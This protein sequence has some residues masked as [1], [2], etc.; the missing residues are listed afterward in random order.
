[1][2]QYNISVKN[3]VEFILRSGDICNYDQ[4]QL[5]N[6][7]AV[8]GTRIHRKIEKKL[9]REGN[10]SEVFLKYEEEFSD[11]KLTIDG[12]A[13][14]IK[15]NPLKPDIVEIK[16]TDI[17]LGRFD[18]EYYNLHWAQA[19]CYA[20]IFSKEN[21][22]SVCN[23]KLIYCNIGT[24]QIKEFVREFK[25]GELEEF[26]KYLLS[27][28]LQFIEITHNW[29]ETRNKSLKN[30]KF[31]FEDYREGQR[32]LAVSV[33]KAIK[34]KT[35]LFA[36][37][38]TGIGKTMSTVFPALKAMGEDRYE[39][40]FYLTAKTTT[41]M[42][43]K[44]SI[45]FLKQKS[46]LCL[47]A[48]TLYAKEKICMCDNVRTACNPDNC[49]Y[50]KGHYDR[51]NSAL[52]DALISDKTF[53][54]D[55]INEYSRKYTICPFEF[56]L[57]LCL[58]FDMIICDYNYVFD[59]SAHLRRFF[60]EGNTGKYVFLIDEAHNLIDRAREMF[61]VELKQNDFLELISCMREMFPEYSR[62]LG[63]INN[64]FNKKR[65]GEIVEILGKQYVFDREN[66]SE[67]I[68]LIT[69]ILTM[70]GNI[71]EINP[72]PEYFDEFLHLYF[73]MAFYIKMSDFYSENFCTYY[74][75]EEDVVFFKLLC[76]DPSDMLRKSFE[77]CISAI[78]F[79]A[80]M[81]PMKYFFK[82]IGGTETDSCLTLASP[83]LEENRCIISAKD[84]SS[85]YKKRNLYYEMTADYIYKT[86]NAKKGNYIVYFPS[87]RYMHIVYDI[88]KVK[89]D[90]IQTI[91]QEK[92]A[93][94]TE[95]EAFIDSFKDDETQQLIGFCVLGGVFSEGIDLKGNRL[96]GTVLVG[97]G[98][99][100][101]NIDKELMKEY[102][103][104][105]ARENY[106]IPQGF[107]YAYVFPGFTKILQSAGR[108]IRSEEDRGVIVLL[109]ERYYSQK[110]I[111]L[112][113]DEWKNVK[114]VELNDIDNLLR[115]FWES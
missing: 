7:R 95:K 56:S 92:S 39:K 66:D 60:D 32:E 73:D 53:D 25:F 90:G 28:Y 47:K 91:L 44:Q 94:D 86:F 67:L 77:K 99:P 37:A 69:D 45:D 81:I 46:G 102:F 50:A 83:F 70:S 62:A 30:L 15:L 76:L 19:K 64:H 14:S 107:D 112:F 11:F 42:L 84:I 82:L 78:L 34:T 101:I 85:S 48:I 55:M 110:Y 57:D 27:K 61:S 63:E 31:P 5:N 58:F 54:F 49:K 2:K 98:L 80:T 21:N 17:D 115:D 96:I 88:F 72:K 51:I 10:I 4:R 71:F 24:Y 74:S 106:E 68:D 8:L 23:V 89:Y 100:Q 108:V 87:Y 36:E 26:F 52:L 20:Y 43:P 59:P 103:D 109:D 40:L 75:V 114:F 6:E 104:Y 13:D 9:E 3:L 93:T 33:Y 18:G 79:S 105:K 65:S 38:P 1:M 29:M 113:P 111:D 22:Y 12:R 97:V 35:K 16:S 41:R